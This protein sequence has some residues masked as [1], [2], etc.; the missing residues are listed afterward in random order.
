[1]FNMRPLEK[2]LPSFKL[3]KKKKTAGVFSQRLDLFMV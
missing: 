2:H 1:M 3:K